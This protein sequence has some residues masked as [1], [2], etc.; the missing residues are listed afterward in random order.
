MQD[1]NP[2]TLDGGLMAAGTVRLKMPIGALTDFIEERRDKAEY[3]SFL[4]LQEL[5]PQVEDRVRSTVHHRSG[6]LGDSFHAVADRTKLAL[7]SS[8]KY[9]RFNE[10]GTAKTVPHPNPAMTR[11]IEW[12]GKQA[13]SM[14]QEQIDAL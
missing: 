5:Q 2:E 1:A 8:L 4:V 3:S 10:Y 13:E 6:E 14:W 9:A 11:T 12:A 7:F